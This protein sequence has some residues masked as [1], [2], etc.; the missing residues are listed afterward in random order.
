MNFIPDHGLKRS[1]SLFSLLTCPKSNLA[2]LIA[3]DT[4]LPIC[5]NSF[6]VLFFL[7][8]FSL[9]VQ[10]VISKLGGCV[11]VLCW[12]TYWGSMCNL[13]KKKKRQIFVQS[14]HQRD[15]GQLSNRAV[16]AANSKRLRHCIL[17]YCSVKKCHVVITQLSP[18]VSLPLLQHV[19]MRVRFPFHW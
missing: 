15:T 14:Y 3:E 8:M 18:P 19:A 9:Y 4:D 7:H 17:L 13:K 1:M 5:Q 2:F 16:W 11:C 10:E 12:D 6:V